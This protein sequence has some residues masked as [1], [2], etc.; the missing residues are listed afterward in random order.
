MTGQKANILI[1]RHTQGASRS[2]Q[3]LEKLGH[4]ATALCLSKIEHLD[5][6]FPKADYDGVILTSAR[7]PNILK[8]QPDFTALSSL[9]V[10]CV[11]AHTANQAAKAGFSQIADQEKDAASL[12][13]TLVKSGKCK[14]VLYPCA[15]NI[16]FDVHEYLAKHDINCQNWPIYSNTLHAPTVV[17]INQALTNTNVI[18]LHSKRI[19]GY[20]FELIEKNNKNGQDVLRDHKIIAI[21]PNV[22][23]VVP[24]KLRTNIHISR[25]KSEQSMV[26]CVEIILKL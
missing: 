25:E 17:E 7:A 16:S 11:G 8:N 15:K 14:N 13:Q 24:A 6:P 4:V 19:A 18:F 10:S 9:P 26:E 12:A 23:S 22:A 5:T 1:L 20:F 3:R 21:S 2:R